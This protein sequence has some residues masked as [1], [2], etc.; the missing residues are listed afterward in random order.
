ML[1]GQ[2]PGHILQSA[3]EAHACRE[4]PK[5]LVEIHICSDGIEE[6]QPLQFRGRVMQQRREGSKYITVESAA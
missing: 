5:E 2:F 1:H 6:T 3:R 4:F